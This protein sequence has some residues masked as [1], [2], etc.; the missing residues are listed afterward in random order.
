LTPAWQYW[1]KKET[2][3]E[4]WDTGKIGIIIR[5][6]FL[7]IPQD[8]DPDPQYGTDLFDNL[9]AMGDVFCRLRDGDCAEVCLVDEPVSLIYRQHGNGLGLSLQALKQQGPEK[10]VKAAAFAQA[11]ADTL[12][13]YRQDLLQHFPFVVQACDKLDAMAAKVLKKAGASM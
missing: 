10:E 6:E 4:H 12:R 5:G 7:R 13:R 9:L 2:V 3:A 11:L 1:P 8:S